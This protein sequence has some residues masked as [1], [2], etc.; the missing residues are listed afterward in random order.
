MQ[1][2]KRDHQAGFSL[3]ELVI[4]MAATTV[5]AAL[6][7]PSFS[8]L[9]TSQR[10][11]NAARSVE[12]ELQMARLKAVSTSRAMRVRLSCPAAGQLRM[13]EVTGVPTTDNATNRCDPV[14]FPTPGPADMLRSTPSLDS[15]VVYL[16]SGTTVS[17][18]PTHLEF[19][20]RGQVFSVSGTGTVTVL[21]SDVV[22]TVSRAGYSKT[23]TINGIGRI[24]LN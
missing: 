13:L 4:V 3:I 14:A 2:Q 12:R 16:P 6:A 15:P 8:T 17:G 21:T 11:A 5:L 19:S 1:F 9:M 20:P 18:T 24:R 7:V 23:V 10:A 22:W